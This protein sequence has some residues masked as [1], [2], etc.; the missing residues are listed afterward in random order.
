MVV[1]DEMISNSDSLKTAFRK[2][3]KELADSYHLPSE[4][5]DIFLPPTH[6]GAVLSDCAG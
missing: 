6:E 2:E 5:S 3:M 1:D 4:D